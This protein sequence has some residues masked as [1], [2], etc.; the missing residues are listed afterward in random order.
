M[1]F[2]GIFDLDE[3]YDLEADPKEMHNRI[4]DPAY[5]EIRRDME[6]RLRESVKQT[7]ATMVPRFK[8]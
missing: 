8:A 1:N 7:G 3:L 5:F 6:N 4:D 2:H